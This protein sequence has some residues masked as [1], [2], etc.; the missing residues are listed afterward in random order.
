M[1][2]SENFI[3]RPIATSLLMAGIALF[4][5]I[6]YRAL[7]VSDLP[8]VDYPTITVSASLPGGNPETMASSVAT[9]LERQFTTIAGLD[10]MISSSSQ[11]NSNITLQFSLDRDIDGATVDVE[12]AIAEAMPLLPPGMPTPPSFHRVNPGDTPILFFF[13]TSPTMRLS[14]L[15]EYAETMVAQRVSMVSGVAQVQVFG[16]AKYAVRVQVDPNKLAAHQI[17]LDEV[18]SAISDWNINLPTGTL[19]GKQ[20]AY[21]V[22]ANGQLMKASQYRPLVVAYRNGA[23][24]RLG[25]VANV[26]DSVQDDKQ[27]AMIYGGEYGKQGTKG[28][29]MAV[30]RQPGS[31]TIDVVDH[32]RALMPFFREQMPPTVHMGI[33]GDRSKNIREAFTDIQFTMA[34]T[35]GLVIMV[36]FLFLRNF[37]ATMIPAMALPF[38]IVG[39]FAVMYLLDFSINNISMMA[40]ILSIGFVVDDA[41]VML[42]NIVRHIENG[43]KPMEAALR[44][45][46][47]INFTIISMTLSLAAV[48]IPILFM[49]GILGRLFRE[50]AVT[51]CAAIVISGIVS[52][53]LTPM[54]CSRFL[55]DTS[56]NSHGRFYRSIE[57]VFNGMLNF[58][59]VTLTWVLHHR[60]VMLAMFLVVLGITGYLYVIV[61]KGFIPDTDNDTFNIQTEATQGTSYYQMV[62]Y[63]NRLSKIVVQDPDVD[64]FYSSTGGGFGGS[65]NTGRISVNL[66]PRRERVASVTDIVNRMRPKVSGL[67]GLKVYLTVPQA[68]RVGGRQSKSAY[69]FTL[70]GP[71]TQQL[72]SEAQK[73]ERVVNRLPG[74][75]EVTSDLQIKNPQVHIVLDRD[76]AAALNVNWSN[77]AGVLYDAFGPQLASTIYSPTNQYQV[78]LEMLPQY[79]R[80]TDGLKMLYLKSNT[81]QLVP[82]NAV[83]HLQE[84]AGPQSIPHSGQLPSVTL[85]FALKPGTSLGQATDE[86]MQAAKDNLPATITGVFQGTAQV[87]RDSMQN[88]GL[89]LILAIAVVYIVL[90]V[91]Y[92]S[93]VHPITILS[94][95]PSAGL[96]ALLTLIIFKVELSIYSFVGMIMLIGIVKK[97]AIMQIDF[98]LEAERKE[99]KSPAE[100]IFEGCLIRFRP[101]M[102]TTMA[103]LLGGLPIALGYGAGGESRKPLGLAVVGG[104]AFSQLMTLYLTPVVYTYMAAIVERTGRKKRPVKKLEPAMQAGD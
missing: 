47:E 25:D 76:R 16:S 18:A 39:A 68:I 7:P 8:Q 57:S 80:Y 59:R 9:P 94:G 90:G 48:F 1:N 99:G 20:T 27:F 26:I 21:N 77:V 65:S 85:S 36:I 66:K 62:T 81:G 31:N 46:R 15:D 6:A 92:E 28:I 103:A 38:S 12:T 98:A 52:I 72:Y 97:N 33:R 44:G 55:R 61:P 96:G 60:P 86:I 4:G 67:P 73:L 17:G 24:V 41:I 32:I 91:L 11:G 79:Q 58:Y 100:A 40:L 84:S 70:F 51:I 101:I 56:H 89:L 30:F 3:R 104:L 83:A 5:V 78:L 49:S 64:T 95:L 22:Q 2:I 102:M 87:F 88:M 37:S 54:L 74:L 53:S 69:D 45:S 42:E 43:E 82:L 35:L 14:D 13:V 75:S 29:T 23:A 19:Y 10:S 93:Y 50:F 71:D 34:A 63:M